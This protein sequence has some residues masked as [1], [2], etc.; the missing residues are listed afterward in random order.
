MKKIDTTKWQ[1]FV[2][3]DLF[4]KLDLRFLPERKF[5]KANDISLVKCEEFNLPLV[6]AKHGNNGIMYYGREC[7]WSS[8]EMSLDI[9]ADGAA[10]TG[11]VYAQPQ[12]TGV[13]Y[14]AYLIKPLTT[15]SENSLIFL[16][17]VTQKCIKDHF[18]Y[19]N[20]CTW[21]KVAL[22]KIV[23]PST[24]EGEPDWDYMDKYMSEVIDEAKGNLEHLV[25]ADG[26]RHIVNITNW[27]RFHLY[28]EGLFE[29]DMGTK[30]DR[31]KMTQVDP[32]VNFVG[33]ANAN[34]GITAQVDRIKGLEPYAAGNMTLSLGG[35]YLGSC[36]V[37]PEAFYTSQNVVVLKPKQEMS[38]AV[39]QFIATMIFRES[40]SYYK[41]F[42]DE[43]NRHIKTDFSFYLPVDRDGKPDWSYM[44]SYMKSLVQQSENDLNALQKII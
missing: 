43:L 12:K 30:L 16:A 38:F 13:L 22:E 19:E 25:Q 27:K 10:S 21:E 31:V 29:I 32:E 39:K 4:E 8:A 41:A 20:K 11:D 18:G 34:N 35:E 7:D 9:V 26:E 6:N 3:G 42:I 36:F 40:R 24:D 15:I 2:I 14:N 44:D 23:L 28:D 17:T 5:S 37:Q 1:A 33:R